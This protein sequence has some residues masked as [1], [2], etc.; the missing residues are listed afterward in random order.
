MDVQQVEIVEFGDLG[1]ARGESEI[2]GREF[3]ER[4][5]GDRH[6]VIEDAVVATAEAEGRRVGDEVHLV[7]EAAS[8]MPSSVATTPEPP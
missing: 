5:T 4:I 2:V 1:H 7:A 6:L 8:S 3:K